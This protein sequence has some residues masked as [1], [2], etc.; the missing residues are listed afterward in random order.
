ML[1]QSFQR[2]VEK[3]F[4]NQLLYWI[5][6]IAKA[7]CFDCCS[8]VDFEQEH[9]CSGTSRFQRYQLLAYFHNAF[10]VLWDTIDVDSVADNVEQ[11]IFFLCSIKATILQRSN[12]LI[13]LVTSRST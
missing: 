11:L 6:T 12:K 2:E 10:C 8:G 13:Q 1:V 7:D 3:W 5:Q 4:F 9:E